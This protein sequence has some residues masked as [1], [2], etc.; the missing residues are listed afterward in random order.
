MS[1]SPSIANFVRRPD[2]SG[3]QVSFCRSCLQ[4]IATARKEAALAV[5][6]KQH[7][8]RGTPPPSYTLPKNPLDS[9]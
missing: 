1:V 6:E 9:N 4:T 8:C 3:A 2:L 5:A 7:K